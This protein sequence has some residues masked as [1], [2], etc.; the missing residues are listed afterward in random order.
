M[1]RTPYTTKSGVQI[2]LLYQPP[3]R[4]TTG[5]DMERL[6]A[7]LLATRNTPARS[8]LKTRLTGRINKLINWNAI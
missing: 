1:K 2:G 8:S 6:Q 5:V 7:A 4:M 3:V